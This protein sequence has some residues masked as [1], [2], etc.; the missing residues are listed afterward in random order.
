MEQAAGPMVCDPEISNPQVKGK[1]Y[2]D[3][4]NVTAEKTDLSETVEKGGRA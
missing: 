3:C 2:D 1:R 4:E